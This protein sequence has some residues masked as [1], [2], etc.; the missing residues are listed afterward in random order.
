MTHRVRV[1][2][3][4]IYAVDEGPYSAMGRRNRWFHGFVAELVPHGVSL[5]DF[6]IEFLQLPQDGRSSG[7]AGNSRTAG[8]ARH[9]RR[10]RLHRPLGAGLRHIPALYFGAHPE[11]NGLEL[12]RR[13]SVAGVRLNLPLIWS[14]DNFS[15]LGELIPDMGA[16]Y[17]PVNLQSEFAFPNVRAAYEEYRRG[18]D[19]SGSPALPGGSATAA[20]SSWPSAS[21]AATTKGRSRRSTS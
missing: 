21:A 15:L 3:S 16:V 2:S 11:N 6:D 4:Y 12:I 8:A 17:I 9:L 14:Y 20:C 10:H 7:P 5:N 13:P 1:L 18:H 19:G